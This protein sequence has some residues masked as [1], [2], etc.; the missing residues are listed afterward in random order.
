M[1]R[2]ATTPVTARDGACRRRRRSG[3]ALMTRGLV[4]AL[5]LAAAGCG[6][7]QVKPGEPLPG[8]TREQRDRFRRGSVVFQ[9]VFTPETGL[10]PLF[11]SSSCAECHED[12]AAGG[13]GDEV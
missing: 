11:N 8:L 1:E 4:A 7:K 9:K 2:C 5:L 6:R 13:F 3:H 12:P 10:G